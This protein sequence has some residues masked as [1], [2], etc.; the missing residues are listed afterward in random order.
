MLS[1][2]T[3]YAETIGMAPRTLILIGLFLGSLLFFLSLVS[4]LR[5]RNTARVQSRMQAAGAG[6]SGSDMA[7]TPPVS[8]FVAPETLPGGF[9]KAF[10]PTDT[11]ERNKVRQDL[12]HAGFTGPSAVLW[13]FGLRVGI[14]LLL[15]A[16]IALTFVYREALPLP[17][18]VSERMGGVRNN[19]LLMVFGVMILIGF[20]GPAMWLSARAGERRQRIELAFPNALDLLQV[21][22]ETGLGFDAALSRVATELQTTAPD[23]SRELQTAQQEILAG[24][25]RESAYQAMATR[26]SIDE[27]HAF[28]NVVLQSARFGTSM[29]QALLT[30]AAEMRQRR[31]LRAQEKANKLP[32]MMS[33]VMAAFMMPALLI[34]TIG[35]V[36]LRYMETNLTGP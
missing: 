13:Y 24:R 32:V 10:L 3:P 28:V 34:V 15:P 11:R 25:D 20:Y 31:E 35:P 30:Y 7:I 29:S 21:S 17:D 16:L 14:G 12:A 5:D 23:I 4:V 8:H 18:F 36:A 22:I 27:A 6:F 33:G 26:L 1:F 2:I 19:Q 9:A